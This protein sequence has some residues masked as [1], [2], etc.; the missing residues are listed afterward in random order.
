MCLQVSAEDPDIGV[1]GQVTYMVVGGNDLF[2]VNPVTG[3]VTTVA[4]L[5]YETQQR[6]Y[7]TVQV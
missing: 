2:T 3:E 5:D 7:V 1:N 6:H 4:A